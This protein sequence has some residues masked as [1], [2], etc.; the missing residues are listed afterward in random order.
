MTCVPGH[1][2]IGVAVFFGC[3]F[4]T[5]HVELPLHGYVADSVTVATTLDAYGSMKSVAAIEPTV[6]MSAANITAHP[7]FLISEYLFGDK[8]GHD[9][10]R[11]HG[12]LKKCR[13]PVLKSAFSPVRTS[14]YFFLITAPLPLHV[15]QVAGSPYPS[16]DVQNVPFP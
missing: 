16:S 7:V 13:D 14:M 5:S 6:V 12:L 10:G 1:T 4:P 2:V 9:V 15:P 8:G 3:V 11:A